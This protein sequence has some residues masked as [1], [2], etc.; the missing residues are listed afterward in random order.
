MGCQREIAAKIVEKKADYILAVKENQQL[1]LDDV[2]DSF[3]MRSP[4]RSIAA[5]G[6]WRRGAVR[7]WAI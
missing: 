7:W 5:T 4:N 6:A 1:L 2:K 3:K